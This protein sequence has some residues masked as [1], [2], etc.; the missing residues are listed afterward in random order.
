MPFSPGTFGTLGAIP[1]AYALVQLGPVPYLVFTLVF[2][3]FAIVVSQRFESF[4]VEHDLS[5]IVI[6][7]VAGFL[8]A[9]AW[10]PST[11]QYWLAGFLLFR[12]FD[13]VKPFPISYLDR[14]IKGGMGVVIDD[15]AAGLVVNVI[16]QWWSGR[17]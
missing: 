9:M 7:E 11:W 10:L 15:V 2:I 14:K 3:V 1:L 6:D 8:V 16:L 13:I 5:E 17:F 4:H 12:F